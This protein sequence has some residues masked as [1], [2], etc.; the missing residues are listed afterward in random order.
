MGDKTGECRKP[1]NPS[2]PFR[3]N[4]LV[5]SRVGLADSE[6]RDQWEMN[7]ESADCG[8]KE[9]KRVEQVDGAYFE[10][11]PGNPPG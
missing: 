11:T 5:G 6:L 1:V 2:P 7:K 9:Y 10:D 4:V 8:W 3:I